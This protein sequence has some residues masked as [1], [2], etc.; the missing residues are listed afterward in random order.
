MSHNRHNINGDVELQ[1]LERSS[2]SAESDHAAVRAVRCFEV[3][4]IQKPDP[5]PDFS[6]LA[7]VFGR[8]DQLTSANV[9]LRGIDRDN[10]PEIDRGHCQQS[11]PE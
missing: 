2:R 11:C 8:E 3:R 10:A 1:R 6:D 7:E 4:L 9:R 5:F